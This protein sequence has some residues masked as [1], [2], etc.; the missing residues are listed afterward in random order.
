M[1]STVSAFQMQTLQDTRTNLHDYL[2]DGRWTV[3]MFWERDCVA[4]EA[5]KPLLEAFHQ[6][7][8]GSRAKAIGVS[9]DGM[10]YLDYIQKNIARHQTSYPNLAVLT[11]VFHWQFEQETKK[12]YR[13]TPTY[14]LYFP[15]GKLA[16]VRHGSMDFNVLEQILN[17]E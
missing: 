17:E 3:V 4:C 8:S 1:T 5:Q 12:K 16:G 15:D 14:L 6:K 9:I 10:E 2:G 7:Y 11:D 13:L